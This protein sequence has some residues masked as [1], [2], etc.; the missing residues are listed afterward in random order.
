MIMSESSNFDE[1]LNK[2]KNA[3]PLELPY[4]IMETELHDKKSAYEVYDEIS[5]QFEGESIIDNV[6]TPVI[7]T[8][9]D[10]VLSLRKFRGFSTK[11]GL[12]AQ[13]VIL[14]CQSFNYDGKIL[15]LMPDS[16][17][18]SKNVEKSM[19]TWGRENRN[20]YLR[21]TLENKHLMNKYKGSKIVQKQGRVNLEDEYR[22]T[23]DI[24]GS[25]K[26]S[27]K[28]RN[29][30]NF[31]YVAETDHIVPLHTIFEQVQNNPAL[32]NADIKKIANQDCN[33]A[34]T[35]RLVNNPKRDMSN[36]EFIAEQDRRKA[37]G[38][39][40]VEL[41]EEQRANMIKME[42]E[43]Q[44]S[45]EN[46]IN[47]TVKMNLIKNGV[48]KDTAKSAG[49]DALL[50]F[51]GNT[52]L[53]IIK[54]LYYEIKDSIIYGLQ[55]G[56]CADSVI[57][58]IKIRCSR[59]GNYVKNFVVGIKDFLHISSEFILNFISALIEGIIGMFIGVFKNILRILKEGYKIG[60]QTFPIL[61]GKDAKKMSKNER[62]D[63][64]VKIIGGSVASLCGIGINYLLEKI[65][66]LPPEA[67]EIISTL[68]SGLL[69]MLL[70]YVLDKADLFD[71]KKDRREQRINEVFE[72]RI[73]DIKEK[74]QKF[75]ET[76]IESLRKSYLSSNQMLGQI[77]DAF[78]NGDYAQL[79]SI[80]EKFHDY[81][82]PNNTKNQLNWD[83]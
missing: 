10:S 36:S 3:S 22:K 60:V 75:D 19:E 1:N 11:L 69:S 21:N 37:A 34:V 44:A 51:I 7:A 64:I 15:N 4:L 50:Y 24:S 80:L 82:F 31:N 23:C 39:D 47:A 55:K 52:I 8:I 72:M 29:D 18:E 79:N 71:V 49:K 35:G 28:R 14:E 48:L 41:S 25:R 26:G 58:A 53:V 81:I 45:L 66:A 73:N 61:F 59:I 83:C 57:A 38:L 68:S 46:N 63:A 20:E 62:G 12:S 43:A 74:A 33:F 77:K 42:K 67:R 27:D 9:I 6:V 16:F 40:Y 13:R 76:V 5:K 17:V 30:P 54:P 32:T 2:I 56:V 70:F 78:T 65:P